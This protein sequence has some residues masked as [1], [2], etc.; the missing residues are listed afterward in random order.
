MGGTSEISW[1][2]ARKKNYS[3]INLALAF[4]EA[5]WQSA[6][7][8]SC[9]PQ[10]EEG[11]FS[12]FPGHRIITRCKQSESFGQHSAP[13]VYVTCQDILSFQVVII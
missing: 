5:S 12:I 13:S 1:G 10:R 6:C 11:W 7:F 2:Q 4:Q 9:S 3:N 8:I